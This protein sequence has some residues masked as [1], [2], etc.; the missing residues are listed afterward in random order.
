VKAEAQEVFGEQFS[1][2]SSFFIH[3]GVFMPSGIQVG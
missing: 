2:F 1:E 3:N